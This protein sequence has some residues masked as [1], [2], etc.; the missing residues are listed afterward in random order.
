M[1]T[2]IEI[3]PNMRVRHNWTVTGIED[4]HGPIAV[5][6]EV[7][8]FESEADLRGRGRVEEINLEHGL[9]YLS[10]DWRGLTFGDAS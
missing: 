8:V 7:E 10:V 4:A 2:R 3:D 6:D 1:S 9:V 5:G